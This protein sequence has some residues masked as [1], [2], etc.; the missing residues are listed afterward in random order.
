[1]FVSVGF[2]D[3]RLLTTAHKKSVEKVFVDPNYLSKMNYIMKGPNY[4]FCL[5]KLTEVRT[6][7]LCRRQANLS[8]FR[9]NQ[10]MIFMFS[11]VEIFEYGC[12]GLLRTYA[13]ST[14]QNKMLY[15]GLGQHG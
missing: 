5:L 3:R 13:G 2:L 12:T 1:M 7:S 9:L 10:I 6:T 14:I 15:L 8:A 11:A 4:D